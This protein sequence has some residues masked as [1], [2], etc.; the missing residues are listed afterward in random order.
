MPLR[1]CA[2]VLLLT[3]IFAVAETLEPDPPFEC[4]P[5]EA[6]SE[7]QEPFRIFGNTYYVGSAGLSSIVIDGDDELFLLDG[8]LPQI[9]EQIVANLRELELREIP[10]V[11]I[12]W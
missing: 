12:N 6:W 8:G 5:C 11:I 2:F 4:P 10:F 1:F 9:A 7:P 3:P